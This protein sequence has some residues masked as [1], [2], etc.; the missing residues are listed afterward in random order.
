MISFSSSIIGASVVNET[1]VFS[2]IDASVALRKKVHVRRAP[3][4]VSTVHIDAGSVFASELVGA[5]HQLLN[6]ILKLRILVLLPVS[7][8]PC[9]VKVENYS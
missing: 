6:I 1:A 2:C 7:T 4:L 9:V 8:L 3:A 5:I